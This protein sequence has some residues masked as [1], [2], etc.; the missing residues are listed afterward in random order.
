MPVCQN[1]HQKWT[2]KQTFKKSFTLDNGMYCPYCEKKQYI[3][4]ASRVRSALILF[5]PIT[6]LNVWN[7]SF[8][9]SM[10]ILYIWIILIPLVIGL[11]PFWV[12]LS[13]TEK[14]N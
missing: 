11:Y 8:G 1:C 6:L 4:K 7:L 13:S 3:T 5:L 10:I 2:W 14:T 9:P 12:E